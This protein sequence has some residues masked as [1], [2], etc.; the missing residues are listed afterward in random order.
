M[1]KNFVIIILQ[2]SKK[3][4]FL[5]ILKNEKKKVFKMYLYFLKIYQFLNMTKI[6]SF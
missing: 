4:L 2:I 3:T 6:N 1:I 5:S